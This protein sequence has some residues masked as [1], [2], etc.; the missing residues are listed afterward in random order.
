MGEALAALVAAIRSLAGVSAKVDGEITVSSEALPAFA[1]SKSTLLF[2]FSARLARIRHLLLLP[3][4]LL[5]YFALR[6]HEPFLHTQKA[7]NMFIG[8]HQGN[9]RRRRASWNSSTVW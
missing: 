1:A 9:E 6:R 2:L 5:L 7:G 4:L 8:V 3:R